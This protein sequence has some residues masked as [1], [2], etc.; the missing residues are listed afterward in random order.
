MTGQ[1]TAVEVKEKI[2]KS[3]ETV[4]SRLTPCARASTSKLNAAAQGVLD[5]FINAEKINDY[6]VYVDCAHDEVLSEL[7]IPPG[8]VPGDSLGHHGLVVSADGSGHG[9]VLNSQVG[10]YMALNVRAVVSVSC[11]LEYIMIDLEVR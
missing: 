4:F 8:T 1:T 5:N 6:K 2:R 10:P 9:L 11:T 3:L 7:T